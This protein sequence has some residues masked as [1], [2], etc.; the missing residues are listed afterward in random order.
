M[1]RLAFLGT[2]E[3][4]M[5]GRYVNRSN[6]NVDAPG[7]AIKATAGQDFSRN[8]TQGGNATS[9]THRPW[10]TEWTQSGAGVAGMRPGAAASSNIHCQ[11]TTCAGD[12]GR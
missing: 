7:G 9:R 11:N 10:G 4:R 12:G 6:T 8:A 5:V 1:A 3:N 2:S